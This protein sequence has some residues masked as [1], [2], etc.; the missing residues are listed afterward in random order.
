ML[1]T[2]IDAS[3]WWHCAEPLDLLDLATLPLP[4]DDVEPVVSRQ[5]AQGSL[6]KERGGA[7]GGQTGTKA[8]QSGSGLKPGVDVSLKTK[9]Q[10]RRPV[11]P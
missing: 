7:A 10:A 8:A 9:P 11:R 3:F 1:Q 6:A 5:G 4:E 2:G